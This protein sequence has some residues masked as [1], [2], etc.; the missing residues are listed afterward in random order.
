MTRIHVRGGLP[1]A[2]FRPSNSRVVVEKGD[3]EA[4]V[5]EHTFPGQHTP[6]A[7]LEIFNAHGTDSLFVKCAE[8]TNEI[9][10]NQFPDGAYPYFA[11][12]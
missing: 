12:A 10:W 7:A 4:H 9:E 2:A 1:L 8:Y 5:I 11:P 6:E 3:Y